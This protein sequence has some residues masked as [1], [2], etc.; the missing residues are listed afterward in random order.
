MPISPYEHP[1]PALELDIDNISIETGHHEG[2]FT[3]KNTGAGT[4]TGHILSRSRALS[5]TPSTWTGNY[6]TVTYTYAP[7]EAGSTQDFIKTNAYITSTGGEITLPITINTTS[8]TIPTAEG[9]TITSLSDFYNYAQEHP[10]AAR[11]LFTSSEFYMFL[12]T[13]GYQY[14][15]IYESL[16]KDVNRERSIDNFFILSGLKGKTGLALSTNQIDIV[17]GPPGKIHQHFGVQKSDS[18]YADAPITIVGG[19]PW[20]SLSTGRLSPSDF[21]SNNNATVELTV[22]PLKIPEN[23]TREYIQVGTT[24]YAGSMLEV[25]FRRAPAFSIELSKQGFRYEDRGGVQV[26]NNTG[27]NIR[28]DVFCRDRYVRFYA[29]SHMVGAAYSIP[30]EIRPSAFASAQRLFRRLPYVST[31]IDVR[32]QSLGQTFHKR[33]HFNIGEW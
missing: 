28:V 21:D 10:Q 12:L 2:S 6:Q 4:L 9:I 26:E 19:A 33:L 7:D 30:F 11:R 27:A 5:F 25:N 16:H 13:T 14:M 31:Y 29:Q 32:V 18:G 22:D 23:F 24:P 17:Q 1:H 8:M 15:D 20:L 3:I